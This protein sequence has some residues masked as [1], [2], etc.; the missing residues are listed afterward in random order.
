MA[1][2]DVPQRHWFRLGRP[3]TV[4][5]GEPALLSWSAT[6]FEYLMP[7]LLLRAYPHTLL[8]ESARLAV[9]HQMAY[10]GSRHIPWGISESAY[11]AVDRDGTYQYRAFGVPGLGLARGLA[12]DLVVAPYATA[13]ALSTA[14]HAA[15]ENLRRLEGVDARCRCGFYESIDFTDR[16]SARDSGTPARKGVPVVVRTC[17]SH[18]QGMALLAVAN[19]LTGDRMVERFHR[20]PAVAATDL[21]LQERVPRPPAASL[22]QADEDARTPASATTVPVRRYRTP[23][24]SVPHAQLLSNG[25]YVVAITNGGGGASAWKGQAVTRWRRDATTDPTSHAIYLRDVRS[26]ASWSAAYQPT[27]A[28]PDDYVVTFHPDKAS[29]QRRDG[30]LA[31][32]LDI[33]VSPEDDVEVRRLTVRNLGART[34]SGGHQLRRGGARVHARRPR[35]PAFGKLFIET[36]CR[37]RTTR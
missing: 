16:R 3:L 21:L 12:D 9:V 37:R 10:A 7:Q 20:S 19:A 14:P 35:A 18:H 36:E 8:G 27:R 11:A 26:G 4:L 23:H 2:G 30:E 33:A 29:I 6:M 22:R 32:Q 1:R 13:L 34:R 31:T 15:V 24:T 25:S 5:H 28:E 17:M